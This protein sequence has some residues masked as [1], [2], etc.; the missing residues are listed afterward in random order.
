VVDGAT[1]ISNEH[2]SASGRMFVTES[3]RAVFTAVVDVLG[4]SVCN[5]VLRT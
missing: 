1:A 2:G 4:D 5:L 3:L